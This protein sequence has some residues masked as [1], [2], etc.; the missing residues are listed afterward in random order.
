MS[1]G[2]KDIVNGAG[3]RNIGA[4]LIR[5]A[6]LAERVHQAEVA[7]RMTTAP[8]VDGATLRP[9]PPRTGGMLRTEVNA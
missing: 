9:I 4:T 1:N 2:W 6:Q 5:L 7:D 8:R 3:D